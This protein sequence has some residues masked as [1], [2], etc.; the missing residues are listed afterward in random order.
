MLRSCRQGQFGSACLLTVCIWLRFSRVKLSGCTVG[1]MFRSFLLPRLLLVTPARYTAAAQQHRSWSPSHGALLWT[2]YTWHD[3]RVGQCVSEISRA[4]G[5]ALRK[6]S[7]CWNPFKKIK[8]Q[9]KVIFRPTAHL[10]PHWL[11]NRGQ[12]KLLWR[13]LLIQDKKMCDLMR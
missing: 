7:I 12:V 9:R 3:I 5:C 8:T 11:K 4:I 10:S 6:I 1:R 2:K 13:L